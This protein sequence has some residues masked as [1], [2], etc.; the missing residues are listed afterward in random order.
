MHMPQTCVHEDAHKVCFIE[1]YVVLHLGVRLL[2]YQFMI[3]FLKGER[4][5]RLV[6]FCAPC[7]IAQ[8]FWMQHF[9]QTLAVNQY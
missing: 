9:V 5:Y 3:S 7:I 8:I 6:S 1:L 2:E 4:V